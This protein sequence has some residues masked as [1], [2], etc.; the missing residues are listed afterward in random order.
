MFVP[1]IIEFDSNGNRRLHARAAG[2]LQDGFLPMRNN[3]LK[4]KI[5]ST[6]GLSGEKIKL[7]SGKKKRANSNNFK[8]LTSIKSQSLYKPKINDLHKSPFLAPVLPKFHMVQK[9]GLPPKFIDN[10]FMQKNSEKILLSNILSP[11]LNILGFKHTNGSLPPIPCNLQ[12]VE[13]QKRIK[14]GAKRFYLNVGYPDLRKALLKRGW[15]ESH[16]KHDDTV[17][18]KFALANSEITQ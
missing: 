10:I 2:T 7:R 12:T 13:P 4:Q 14:T 5:L 6:S 17:D 18:L 9:K 15:Y 11:Q 16:D 8:Q 1:R 3:S